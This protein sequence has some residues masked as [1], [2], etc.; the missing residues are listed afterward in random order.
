[1]VTQEKKTK[2]E[3]KDYEYNSNNNTHINNVQI[4]TPNTQPQ[5]KEESTLNESFFRTGMFI[6]DFHS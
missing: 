2:E 1:M 5:I 3:E 4:F 6:F